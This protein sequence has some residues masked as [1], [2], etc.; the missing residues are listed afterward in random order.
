MV[1]GWPD[2]RLSWFR[3]GGSPGHFRSKPIQA[4]GRCKP[5]RFGFGGTV[6]ENGV[7]GGQLPEFRRY[8]DPET[9]AVLT[10]AVIP[11][12]QPEALRRHVYTISGV[13][14]AF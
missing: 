5:G 9:T 2:R 12:T 1:H 7:Q 10:P 6:G 11:I 14:A 8:R 13:L 3:I 4:G